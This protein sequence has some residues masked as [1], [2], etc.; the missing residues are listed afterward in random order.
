VSSSQVRLGWADR[1]DNETGFRVER[2]TGSGCTTYA[3]VGTAA[4]GAT[5]YDD[6]GLQ[7]S[8]TYGYRV[9]ATN[10]GGTSGYS[11]EASA[12]TAA[13]PPPGA[14]L[15]QDDFEDG[16]ADGWTESG[17]TWTVVSDGTKVY[18]QGGT[19]GDGISAAGDVGWTDFTVEVRAKPVGFNAGGGFVR[20]LARYRDTGNY[21]YLVL[22]STQVL[23]L[24]KMVGG[25]ATTLGSK[26]FTVTTEGWHTLRLEVVGT[27]LKGYVNG[28]LQLSAT[29]SQLGSGRI[30]VGTYNASAVFDD[31]V[32]RLPGGTAPPGDA[33]LDGVQDGTDNCPTVANPAQ[34]DIEVDGWGDMCDNC[35]TV[36]NATQQDSDSDGLGNV[37]EDLRVNANVDDTGSSAGRIDGSDFF[38][39]ARA[40]GSRRGD[41]A[42]DPLVDLNRDRR[43]DGA[44]LALLASVWGEAVP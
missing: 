9:A 24:K 34:N 18:R 33:D 8:T 39:L 11:N 5:T 15:Y 44:D 20:L 36:A 35:P 43:V 40:F 23:E 19:S 26:S 21:Y 17:G 16:V 41:T 13:P 37:C 7:A 6:G 30:G 25:T 1:S 3:L 22:R 2:C 29:D 32:V 27:S 42:F 4:A 10:G 38:R 28:A 14:I 12:T 31:M